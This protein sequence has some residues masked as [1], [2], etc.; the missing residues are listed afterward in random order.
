MPWELTVRDLLAAGAGVIACVLIGMFPMMLY[1]KAD[2]ATV[3]ADLSECNVTVGKKDRAIIEARLE[4]ET[5]GKKLA[6]QAGKVEV[7]Y[8]ERVHVVREKGDAIIQRVPVYVTAEA[9]RN[10]PVPESFRLLW[11][12]ANRGDEAAI[13]GAPEGTDATPSGIVL[14]GI[15]SQHTRESTY[16]RA[17]EQQVIGL[18]DYV[19]AV[20]N[21]YKGQTDGTN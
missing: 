14:S 11:N 9:D 10:C 18:Q 21:A 13:A 20:H 16:C 6:E 17:I 2:V 1:Y 8:V 12:A 7:Q 19:E 4:V 3:K 5:A 15:A